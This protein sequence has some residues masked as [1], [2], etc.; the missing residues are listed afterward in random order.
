[1]STKPKW[2]ELTDIQR[3]SWDLVGPFL[4][5]HFIANTVF[6]AAY[7]LGLTGAVLGNTACFAIESLNSGVTDL[8]HGLGGSESLDRI[9]QLYVPAS[10]VNII[11]AAIYGGIIILAQGVRV[12]A[13]KYF[14]PLLVFAFVPL[15]LLSLSPSSS[16]TSSL[17]RSLR[18]GSWT[19][20]VVFLFG[21]PLITGILAVL[22]L[23]KVPR[24]S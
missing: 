14:L 10:F 12:V 7:A 9:C 15:I 13:S 17:A 20:Y 6:L 23:Q 8:H 4:F 24:A 11:F 16:M 19:A 18:S 3:W 5:A 1:M 2:A 22:P 21:I